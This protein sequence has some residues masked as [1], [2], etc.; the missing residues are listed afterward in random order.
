MKCC[1][2]KKEIEIKGTWKG[3]NNAMPL[4]KGRCCDKCNYL[5]VIPARIKNLN[6]GGEGIKK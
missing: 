5:K 6:K 1:L 2:C 4:K 3:G